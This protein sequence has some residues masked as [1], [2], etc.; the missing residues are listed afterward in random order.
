MLYLAPSGGQS[1]SLITCSK[2][3]KQSF[4]KLFLY[5][6]VQSH[7]QEKGAHLSYPRGLM[8]QTAKQSDFQEVTKQPKG[9][10]SAAE[11]PA[12]LITYV[13]FTISDK[14]ELSRCL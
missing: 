6:F 12:L 2:P 5:S 1:D 3:L 11:H 14:R 9:I 4:K 7:S 13:I 8:V 10:K